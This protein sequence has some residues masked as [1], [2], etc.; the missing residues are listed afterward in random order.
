MKGIAVDCI[1]IGGG[2]AGLTAA[3]YLGRYRRRVTVFDAGS[4]R[5]ALI[6]RTQ[7]YPGFAEGITGL[8]LL[9]ALTAQAENYGVNLIKCEAQLGRV[10]QMFLGTRKAPDS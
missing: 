9:A 7:N 6:P 2:P 1:I 8:D 3:I 10:G 4:S 5:A